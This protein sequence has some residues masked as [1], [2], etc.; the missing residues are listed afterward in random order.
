MQLVARR[1]I[2]GR[3][4][5][6]MATQTR[7]NQREN[8]M[9]SDSVRVHWTWFTV[10]TCKLIP[11]DAPAP[12][13]LWYP[14]TANG[15]GKR[16]TIDAGFYLARRPKC[17]SVRV[18]RAVDAWPWRVVGCTC[19]SSEP[20][21]GSTIRTVVERVAVLLRVLAGWAANA[22][23]CSGGPNACRVSATRACVATR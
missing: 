4:F 22:C 21:P 5:E 19:S 9:F 17:D 10:S 8:Q 13:Q 1:E 23:C 3:V 15:A 12:E 16:R 14:Y 6:E 11:F 18:H 20:F 7:P 2:R